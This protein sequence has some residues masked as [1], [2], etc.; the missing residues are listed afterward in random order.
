MSG[1]VSAALGS[2]S[3]SSCWA[4]L[5]G[6][7]RAPYL[8]KDC[9]PEDL[10]RAIRT[11]QADDTIMAPEIARKMLLAFE[12]AEEEPSTPGLTE[13]ELEVVIAIARGRGDK[14]IARNLQISERAVS[15]QVFE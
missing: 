7:L 13:R 9:T 6:S 4:L 1:R 12:E 8:L 3:Q 14:Q 11:V 2:R 10:G 5:Q 15:N